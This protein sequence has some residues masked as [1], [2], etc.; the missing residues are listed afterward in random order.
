MSL[1]KV[2]NI[3]VISAIVSNASIIQ[4]NQQTINLPLKSTS[5]GNLAVLLYELDNIQLNPN[6]RVNKAVMT[7]SFTFTNE[8]IYCQIFVNGLSKNCDII[9]ENNLWGSTKDSQP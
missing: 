6:S 4:S 8:K 7:G 2:I 5:N 9:K 3:L 1:I